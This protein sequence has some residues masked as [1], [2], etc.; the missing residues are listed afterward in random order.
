VSG[1]FGIL[2]SNIARLIS[3]QKHNLERPK[4]ISIST[5]CLSATLVFGLELLY[6]SR[7]QADARPPSTDHTSHITRFDAYTPILHTAHTSSRKSSLAMRSSKLSRRSSMSSSL[8]WVSHASSSPPTCL[9][10]RLLDQVLIIRSP[11]HMR[12]RSPCPKGMHRIT[13]TVSISYSPQAPIVTSC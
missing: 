10:S 6:L 13:T 4:A 5:G 9:T 8:R 7:P 1:L 11:S 12:S 3:A 2:G